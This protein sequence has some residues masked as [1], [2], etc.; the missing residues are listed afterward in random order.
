MPQYLKFL[1]HLIFH[2]NYQSEVSKKIST[3]SRLTLHVKTVL[4]RINGANLKFNLDKSHFD[5][6]TLDVL[7]HEVH[8][9]GALISEE[10]IL[11][12]LD[13][14]KQNLLKWVQPNSAADAVKSRRWRG[15]ARV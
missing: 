4:E 9:Q 12:A 10:K 15:S 1:K 14:S 3:F 6:S 5:F 13:F 2:N 11:T 7:G 8:A